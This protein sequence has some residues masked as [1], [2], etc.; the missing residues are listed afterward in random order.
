MSKQ[1]KVLKLM[2]ARSGEIIPH[3]KGLDAYAIHPRGDRRCRPV[4][5]LD[6]A[7][8]EQ[9]LASGTVIKQKK[10]IVLAPSY[11]RRATA[12]KTHGIGDI[13]A[14]QHRQ[15][16]ARDIYHPDGIKRPARI[17]VHLSTLTRLVNQQGKDGQS[18][19]APDEIEA[20][21][22][23]ASDY[24]RSMIGAIATQNYGNSVSRQRRNVNT[25]EHISITAL[26]ARK[27]VMEA[28]KTVG[29][30]LDKALTS[31][32]GSDMTMGALETSENWAKGSGKTILKLALSRLSAYYGCR[33]GVGAKRLGQ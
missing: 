15:I 9:L 31:L 21:G 22:R 17:N 28:L 30:G 4:G 18:F 1:R 2:L 32:C 24:A 7:L 33:A 3:D 26:D 29:P 13:Y 14:N 10:S 25:A 5:W 20:A 16:E 11:I 8:L 19:L 12:S 23:F 27:R 6:T